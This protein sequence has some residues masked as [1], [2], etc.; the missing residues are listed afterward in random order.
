MHISRKWK[1]ISFHFSF[2][3]KVTPSPLQGCP[4][5]KHPAL[6]TLKHTYFRTLCK[7][8]PGSFEPI[9][10]E[11]GNETIY[12]K[13]LPFQ[14]ARFGERLQFLFS[15]SNWKFYMKTTHTTLVVT[16]HINILWII[17]YVCIKAKIFSRHLFSIMNYM[18]WESSL[19]P[20]V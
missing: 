6:E 3:W 8:E 13:V 10:G 7:W 1:Y 18:F 5:T 15:Y 14:K 4:W 9:L 19:F 11:Q 16:T 17:K 2:S 20:F 12:G